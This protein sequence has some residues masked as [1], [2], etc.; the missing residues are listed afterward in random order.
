MTELEEKIEETPL[1]LLET[2]Y[3]GNIEENIKF[4]RACMRDSL[5]RGEAPFA[6]HLLYTQEG[7]LDDDIPEQR[8]LGIAAGLTWGRYADKTVVYTNLGITE[9]ME[10]GIK[11]A[12][13]EGREVEYRELNPW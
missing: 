6:M 1:V 8:D 10:I 9:G 7:I 11:R 3:A 4:A 13:E 2:P 5:N 12:R